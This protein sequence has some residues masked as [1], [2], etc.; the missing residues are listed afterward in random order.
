MYNIYLHYAQNLIKNHLKI[1]KIRINL[2]LMNYQKI[3]IKSKLEEFFCQHI[4]YLFIQ[5]DITHWKS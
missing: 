4:Y 2:N 3:L 1:C 5:S